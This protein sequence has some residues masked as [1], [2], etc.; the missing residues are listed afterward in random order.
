ME[1]EIN[2]SILSDAPYCAANKSLFKGVHPLLSDIAEDIHRGNPTCYLISG[3]RGSGKS[4][5]IMMLEDKVKEM[6]KKNDDKSIVVKDVLFIHTSFSKYHSQTV[7]L[8]KLIRS[9]YQG[10]LDT[11]PYKKVGTNNGLSIQDVEDIKNLYE[12]TFF[13]KT[14][15][16]TTS[17]KKETILVLNID[18]KALAKLVF[19]VLSLFLFATNLYYSFL[20]LDRLINWMGSFLSLIACIIGAI[21]LSWKYQRTKLNQ[22]DI[23]RKSLYDDEIADYHFIKTLKCLGPKYN[24]VFVLDELDKVDEEDLE[25]LLKEMKPH[26]V[27]G[28]ATFIAVAGQHL[29]Y[30]YASSSLEDDAILSSIFS[31]VIHIN[32]LDNKYLQDLFINTIIK[33]PAQYKSTEIAFLKQYAD[34]L[35]FQSKRVPRKFISLIRE[36]LT[37]HD[38]RAVIIKNEKGGNYAIYSSILDVIRKVDQSEIA[39]QGYDEATHDYFV[40]KLFLACHILVFNRNKSIS[41]SEINAS[42]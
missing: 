39:N 31:K 8:R 26:L 41:I 12:R 38:G 25:S 29:Y 24:L 40:M 36:E 5:F 9:L 6:K 21:D 33:D 11:E 17:D 1:I 3:Y 4:S 30:K 23:V 19:P 7:L 42:I 28:L 34:Y 13:D 16:V 10:L 32:L 35:T 18:I 14:H 22:S 15:S 20:S 37:Y 27:S 2:D